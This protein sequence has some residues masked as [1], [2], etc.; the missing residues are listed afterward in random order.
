[1]TIRQVAVTDIFPGLPAAWLAP[2]DRFHALGN[3]IDGIAAGPVWGGLFRKKQTK[4]LLQCGRRL[5]AVLD[6]R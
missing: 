3:A 1:M 6:D 5:R 4:F 2:G